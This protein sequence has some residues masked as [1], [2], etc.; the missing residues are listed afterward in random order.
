MKAPPFAYARARSLTEALDLL[1][2]AGDEAKLLAGGQSLIPLLAYRIAR[3]T[4]LVDID[5][6]DEVAGASR[7]PQGFEVGALTR[8]SAI[9]SLPL[10]G[11][12]QLLSEAASHIGHLP[13][14]VR[15]TVGGSIAHADP[16]AELPVAAVA[17]DAVVVARSAER[18]RRIRAEEF[19]LGPF[20]TALAPDE[21]V[22]ALVV[23][24][25][26]IKA[27]SAFE[28]FAI[29]SGDFA[30][31]SAAAALWID[32]GVVS[33]ARIVLGG[34]GAGPCRVRE[35]ESGLLG[36]A[37]TGDSIA[38]AAHLAAAEFDPA[39]STD[40]RYLRGLVARLVRDGLERIRSGA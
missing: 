1:R 24:V 26:A 30:L 5:R 37:L 29:R 40:P 32:D 27:K 23:P 6:V 35:A 17:L 38:E 8:H 18:T 10:Q 11:G 28:E 4:H 22:T 14:R 3:P 25:A 16:A 34:I 19:F 12:E 33:R 2:E 21:A 31:A 20:T 13:I 9:E 7:T 15:G 39:G 36:A